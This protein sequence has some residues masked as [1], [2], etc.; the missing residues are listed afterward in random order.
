MVEGVVSVSHG[1]KRPRKRELGPWVPGQVLLPSLLTRHPD[2]GETAGG[3]VLRFLLPHPAAARA[4]REEMERV[5][6]PLSEGEAHG[7]TAHLRSP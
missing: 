5:F 1:L 4:D 3:W 6:S 2:A 7:F